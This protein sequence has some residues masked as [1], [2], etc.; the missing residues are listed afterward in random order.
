MAKIGQEKVGPKVL[1]VLSLHERWP[2]EVVATDLFGPLPQTAR[3]ATTTL[4]FVDHFTKR[5]DLSALR[6]AEVTDVI[7]YLRDKWV[8]QQRTSMASVSDSGPQS[9]CRR[10][11]LILWECGDKKKC[12]TM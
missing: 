4:V 3:G 6:K 2:G 9:V 11:A 12:G 7:A 5:A 10:V 8:P 1:P